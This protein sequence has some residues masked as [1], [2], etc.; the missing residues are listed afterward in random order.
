MQAKQITEKA[1]ILQT[2]TF[3]SIKHALNH[4]EKLIKLVFDLRP[5]Q[6]DQICQ[7]YIFEAH[8]KAATFICIGRFYM[9]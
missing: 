1:T 5:L 4:L 7:T 8:N 3:K 9:E 2:K 6:T